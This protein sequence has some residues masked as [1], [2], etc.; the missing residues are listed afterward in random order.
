MAARLTEEQRRLR[1]IT[2]VRWQHEVTTVA[3]QAGWLW[4]HAPANRPVG[5]RILNIKAGF[6]DLVLVR[7]QRLIWVEL[8]TET[9]KTTADQDRWLDALGRA[10]QECYVWRPRDRAEMLETLTRLW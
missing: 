10:G 2:E 5:G 9:G 4:Y 3:T 7:R 6:P 8:K 1:A